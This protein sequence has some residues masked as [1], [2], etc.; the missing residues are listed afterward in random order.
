MEVNNIRFSYHNKPFIDD[1]S[2]V[3]QENKITSII[4]PNGS[5]KS[6]LLMLLSRIY[7]SNEGV[8]KLNG[9]NI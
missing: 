6:T 1:L 2:V 5:G 3:F 8:I 9:K 7:K 4:G